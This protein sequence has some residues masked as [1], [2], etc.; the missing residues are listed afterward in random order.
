MIALDGNLMLLGSYGPPEPS[1]FPCTGAPCDLDFG[2]TPAV[3]QP[4]ACPTMV[5]AGNKNGQLYVFKATDLAAS[6]QPFQ[7][8]T[9]NPANDS[10][11]SGGVG[12]VPA[13]WQAG[14][15]LFVSD[16]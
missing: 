1:Q 8:I 2:A 15:L 4:N 11:G 12:G 9:L 6:A 3:F 13:F 14:N 16:V 7:I 5:A 10:L